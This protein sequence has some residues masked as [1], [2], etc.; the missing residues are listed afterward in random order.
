MKKLI[1]INGTMGTGKSTISSALNKVLPQSILLDGDWCWNMDPFI[2][3]RETK[4]IVLDNIIHLLNNFLKCSQY[5][6]IIFCWVMHEEAIIESIVSKLEGRFHLYKI[7]LIC[8]DEILVK[9]LQKDIDKGLRKPDIIERSL[10]RQK[11]YL[12]MNTIKI[13]TDDLNIDEVVQKI[14]EIIGKSEG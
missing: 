13:S 10:Q 6:N 1:F 3:T 14:R 11:N 12:S 4:A 8:S 9:R 2:V 7:S 5:Q